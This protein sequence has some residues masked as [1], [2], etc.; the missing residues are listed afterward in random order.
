[1]ATTEKNVK[2]QLLIFNKLFLISNRMFRK[3]QEGN[4]ENDNEIN[5]LNIVSIENVDLT[6]RNQT[7]NSPRTLEACNKLGVQPSELYQLTLDQ[8]KKKYPDAIG[9]SE[10]ILQYRYDAEE[11]FRK[12]TVEQV[13]KLREEIIE[14]NENKKDDSKTNK[15]VN[16]STNKGNIIDDTN[17]KWEKIIENEKKIL[18]K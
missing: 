9:L 3:K 17:E 13:K 16:K 10:K 2:Y 12:E 14:E 6:K 11:K 18:K 8:F 7:I 4:E 15:D 1:M 5:S